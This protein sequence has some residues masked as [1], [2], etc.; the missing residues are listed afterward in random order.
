MK[1]TR[2][3]DVLAWLADDAAQRD[4]ETAAALRLAVDERL[5]ASGVALSAA[6]V[7]TVE[8]QVKAELAAETRARLTSGQGWLAAEVARRGGAPFGADDL[9][10]VIGPSGS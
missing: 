9:D 2:R 3:D 8:E 5:A 7:Q 4:R 1:S 6:E 10:D